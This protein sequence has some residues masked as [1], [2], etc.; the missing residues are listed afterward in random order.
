MEVSLLD[1]TSCQDGL[2]LSQS[3][4]DFTGLT[5][6]NVAQSATSLDDIPSLTRFTAV[7]WKV[8]IFTMA[9]RYRRLFQQALPFFLACLMAS[10]TTATRLDLSFFHR[11][12]S[13]NL[14][15]AIKS[16]LDTSEYI[17][18]DISS[19]LIGKE[20][21]DVL[22]SLTENPADKARSIDLTARSNNWSQKEA[23]T[24][25]EAFGVPDSRRE[26]EESQDNNTTDLTEASSNA[27]QHARVSLIGLDLSWNDFAQQNR[28]SRTFMKALQRTIRETR[29][30]SQ[31]FILRLDVC[32]LNPVACRAI[33][34]NAGQTYSNVHSLQGII[35]RYEDE[36]LE[37]RDIKPLTLHLT[38][39]ENVGD[40]GAA[41]LAAAIR[42]VV[43]KHNRTKVFDVLNLAG[44]GIGDTGAEALAIV[45]EEHPMCIRHL[46]LSSN[47]I[48]DE[49]A[50][51]L[52][53]ALSSGKPGRLECL[54]LSNNKDIG[55]S[56]ALALAS[57]LESGTVQNIILRS[58][59]VRAD[60]LSSF[61]KA[62]KAVG[63][64]DIERPKTI[65]IDLS[66][67]PFGILRKKVKS[68]GY[69]ATALRSK[70][71]ATTAAYMNLIGKRVQRGLKEI[72]FT[73]SQSTLES[74]D[75]EEGKMSG[76][77]TGT[78]EPKEMICG[79]LAFADAFLG[80]KKNDVDGAAGDS[81]ENESRYEVELGLRHCA[82]D[83]RA[84]E[85]LAAIAHE[86]R[87][88]MGL[89]VRVD[90][91]MNDV[92]EEEMVSALGG[93]ENYHE[94]LVEMAERHMEAMEAL[95]IA[96][97]RAFE[98][99]KAAAKRMKAEAEMEGAWGRPVAM[100]EY[101]EYD[102][103]WDSDGD[104][105]DQEDIDDYF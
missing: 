82:F 93:D 29:A 41:A 28:D 98:A 6:R 58:C 1:G 8:K 88:N 78:G 61:A 5:S 81:P 87:L 80:N 55:D 50:A 102:E 72:G 67:N 68:N 9:S 4:S 45:L 11:V 89:K 10:V 76:D 7:A 101:D 32:S 91:Q 33:G 51:A 25:L 26:K 85:A 105:D 47:Q 40:A 100:P 36:S 54:N 83:T 90:V 35:A 13:S 39:N 57:A 21:K 95:R 3:P 12:K 69:S 23:A 77:E 86:A 59:H 74:D 84:A 104:Y 66:G 79:A 94:T 46:D 22:S 24:L 70:A 31:S 34:K 38:R 60:G 64:S 63:K 52:G 92:L 18:I 30:N 17:E 14:A 43:A 97:Q 42:S 71:S 15:D 20:L 99:A 73:E 16:T 65:N 75:E 2:E 96:R 19:S 37:I 48:S 103:K 62:L 44:C 56:G 49:G 53:H 27:T